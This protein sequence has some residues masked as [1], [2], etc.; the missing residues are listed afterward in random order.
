[1][2]TLLNFFNNP[3]PWIIELDKKAIYNDPLI[4]EDGHYYYIY[5]WVNLET[6]WCYIGKHKS[7]NPYNTE[8]YEGSCGNPHYKHSRKI[9][10]FEFTI[11]GYYS[12]E[13]SCLRAEGEIVDKN[14]INK[15]KNNGIYNLK[16]G[17][18]GVWSE[19]AL[20]ASQTEEAKAKRIQVDKKNHNGIMG[21]HT[22]SAQKKRLE[23]SNRPEAIKA[24]LDSNRRNHGG[25]EAFN[26]AEAKQKSKQTR[27]DKYNGDPQGQLHTTEVRIKAVATEYKKYGKL[28]CH[29]PE[30]YEA[31]RKKNGGVLPFNTPEAHEHLIISRILNV[32]IKTL[33]R[34]HSLNIEI[35]LENYDK[36]RGRA[37]IE[38]IKS[39]IDKLRKDSRWT[40]EMEILFN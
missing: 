10:Q 17:G 28:K 22:L 30:V 34:L 31:V 16:P 21:W 12:T 8:N 27:M 1:M 19:E 26:T 38:T 4:G 13:D 9:H 25:V 14:I 32:I 36:Y 18:K 6:Q 29:S 11:L 2:K 37:R 15:Y 5:C 33:E 3:S 24:R 39:N 7:D 23:N 35:T 20:I 40:Q